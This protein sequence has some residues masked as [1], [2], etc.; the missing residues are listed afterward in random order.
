M[1]LLDLACPPVK[2]VLWCIG[3]PQLYLVQQQT[4]AGQCQHLVS[5]WFGDRRACVAEE[6]F[7]QNTLSQAAYRPQPAASI[8]QRLRTLLSPNQWILRSSRHSHNPIFRSGFSRIHQSS[9][10]LGCAEH[11]RPRKLSDLGLIRC[12]DHQDWDKSG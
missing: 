12:G 6:F 2:W 5:S 7:D 9:Q 4:G 3:F 11:V 1:H 10:H 8:N